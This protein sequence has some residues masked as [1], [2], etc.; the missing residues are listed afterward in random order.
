MSIAA[1]FYSQY[2]YDSFKVNDLKELA[3][4]VGLVVRDRPDMTFKSAKDKG[5]PLFKVA[6]GNISPTVNGEIALRD[7][8]GVSKG[9]QVKGD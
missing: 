2:G 3:D 5:K 1:Y 4:K 6:G 7:K 8:Y 9:Q